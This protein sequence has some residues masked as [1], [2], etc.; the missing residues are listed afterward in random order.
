MSTNADDVVDEIDAGILKPLAHAVARALFRHI[1]VSDNVLGDLISAFDKGAKSEELSKFQ[2]DLWARIGTLDID[3]QGGLRLAVSLIRPD[4][5]IDW[6][7]AEYF[8]LW[9]R[10][11][12]VSEGSI[13]SA[14]HEQAND[15]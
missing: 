4:E 10:Q 8:V 14:F 3:E 1:P 12:G 9:A 13:Y 6:H 11:Q 2:A 7:L 5:A 15:N